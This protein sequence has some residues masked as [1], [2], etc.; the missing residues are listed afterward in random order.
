MGLFNRLRNSFRADKTQYDAND[1]FA[2]HLEQ[3]TKELIDQGMSP[4]Q[5]RAEAQKR[6]GNITSLS[7]QTAETDSLA[8]LETFLR[9]IRLAVRMLG[10]APGVTA[11]AVLSLCLGIGAN[12]VV[13]TLMKQV[14]LDYLPVPNP[15]QLVILHSKGVEEGHVYGNGMNSSFS[16]PL[17]RDLNAATGR[18][19][20]GILA[21]REI[22]ISLTGHDNTETVEAGL[23]SGNFFQV[24]GVNPWRGRLFVSADDQKPQASPLAVL[25]FGLW[26]RSFGGDPNIINK[27]I[28]VNKHPYTVIGIAPPQFY[29]IDVSQRSD[30]YVP[31]CM[32][33]DVV[34]DARLL[35]DRL[36]HWA[37]LIAR[38]QPGVTMQ[39]AASA[40]SVIYP[41]IRDQD[42][43][44]M[45]TPSERF[46]KEFAQKKILLTDGGQ[47]YASLRD[48]LANPLKILMVMVGIVL[49]ITIANVANLLVARGV[50]RQREMAIRLSVGAGRSALIR[51][52]LMESV[53]LAMLGGVLGLA[54]AYAGTPALL[55][56][57]SFDLSAASISARPDWHVMLFASSIAIAAGLVFGLLPALQSARTDVGAALKTEGGG[58]H[59]GHSGWLRRTLVVAQ[60]ALSLVLLTS[61][62]LFTRSLANLK[63]LNVGFNTTQLLKFE[64]NPGQAGYSLPE[65]KTLTESLRQKIKSLPGVET[66]SLAT[67]PLLEDAD[68]GG[69]VTVEGGHVLTGEDEPNRV[70]KN[71]V[72]PDFFSTMQI[73]L[74]AGR[75]F[76]S[77][78]TSPTAGTAIVNQSFV[79]R[80]LNGRN[81]IGVRFGSGTGNNVKFDHV[82][83]GVVADSKHTT[84]QSEIRPFE[85]EPYL[86]STRLWHLNFYVRFGGNQESVAQGVRAAVHQTDANL[87]VNQLSSM[88]E[89]IDESLFVQRSLGYLS[90]GFALLATLLAVIGL[91]G[92]MS[93]SVSSRYRE[94]GIRMAI[95]ATPA[96]VLRSVL[97]ESTYLGIGG[98]LL[99]LPFV[100]AASRYIRS[101]L[102]GVQPDNLFTWSSA[103]I[104]LVTVALLAGLVPAWKA[105]RIDPHAALRTQ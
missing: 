96:R 64:I 102:Y 77:T 95:G 17:Y 15:Q 62:M 42:L 28:L 103:V 53:V 8:W 21:F 33:A 59:T 34:E 91:Y 52:L 29:G 24:L 47:G 2:W 41:P 65:I 76:S 27:T 46:R 97:R 18:V 82:I 99:G 23:V 51:Q 81:P 70:D 36:D 16:Y 79:K 78:D 87:P 92:V 39:Q 90:V 61:A 40:L 13:F 67:I 6:I 94:L 45:K 66:V 3:R 48:D 85:Y 4:E 43:A 49:L 11:V 69:D 86:A 68:S 89:I 55:H 56:T 32:K 101:S 14:V 26:K 50:V 54:I 88:T 93:Y 12:T 7:E 38:M 73:P 100:I 105:A 58:G 80:Y 1:E 63:N 83:V 25:G 9:D 22:E 30:L 104:L 60:V 10:R 98:T 19:F 75:T 20:Q 74:L 5:A 44:S 84:L 57:L 35:T 31:M 72:D 71:Q 37:S